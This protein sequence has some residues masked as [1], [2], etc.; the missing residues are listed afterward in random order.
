MSAFFFFAKEAM[1]HLFF[2]VLLKEK[3]WMKKGK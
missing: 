3:K 1:Q 2:L